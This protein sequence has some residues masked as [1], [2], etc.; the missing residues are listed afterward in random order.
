MREWI[1]K[2]KWLWSGRTFGNAIAD[3]MTIPRGI[4]HRAMELGGLP[5]PEVVLAE[6]HRRGVSVMEARRVIAP[7][8]IAGVLKLLA[9]VG[10]EDD[11]ILAHSKLT[12]QFPHSGTRA[13]YADAFKNVDAMVKA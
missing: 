12:H 9:Q 2:V 3:S 10:A 5:D 6:I 1:D 11:F 4:F 13:A 8:V 7:I